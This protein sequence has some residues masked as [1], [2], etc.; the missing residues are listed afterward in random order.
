M[1]L[2]LFVILVLAGSTTAHA[3]YA[4]QFL[5][6]IAGRPV[7]GYNY[8][9]SSTIADAKLEIQYG[10]GIERSFMDLFYNGQQML[11]N[12]I[13][14][15]TMADYGV[16]PGSFIDVYPSI[17]STG[18]SEDA[19]WGS[20]AAQTVNIADYGGGSLNVAKFTV[21]GTWDLAAVPA[22]NPITFLLTTSAFGIP[23]GLQ[24]FD[25]AVSASW[26]F[27]TTLGGIQNY[28]SDKFAINTEGFIN[29]PTQG[30]FSVSLS[31]NG[32]NLDLIY[33][34]PEPSTGGIIG[35]GGLVLFLVFR[36]PFRNT[37]A[38]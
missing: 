11:D 8:Y 34:V 10:T 29:A 12:Y 18:I 7:Q 15:L 27:I 38:G 14:P 17:F 26:S 20:G 3:Q 32:Q 4:G 30:T 2:T 31:E 19:S 13:N 28:S 21:L 1:K 36:R 22:S 5:T 23:V 24:N 25:P 6:R 33:A 37:L 35:L 9:N 16:I